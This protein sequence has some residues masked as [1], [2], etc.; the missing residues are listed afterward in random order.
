MSESKTV[1]PRGKINFIFLGILFVAV[2]IYGYYNLT[3][4]DTTLFLPL[5]VEIDPETNEKIT[6]GLTIYELAI[7]GAH[8]VATTIA[9]I[10]AKQFWHTGQKIL[11][12][13]YLALSIGMLGNLLGWVG[14]FYFALFDPNVDNNPY[15]YWNDIAFMVWHAGALVHLRLTTHRFQP[16]LNPKQLFVLFVIPVSIA[17]IYVVNY[18][19]EAFLIGDNGEFTFNPNGISVDFDEAA[20]YTDCLQ[21]CYVTSISFVFLNPLMFSYALVGLSVFRKGILGP[22]WILL[23]LGIGLTLFADI[24][25]YYSE[26]FADFAQHDWYTAFYFAS[27]LIMAY[28]LYKHRDL[29]N[30]VSS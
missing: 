14:W 30:Y 17:G 19:G 20:E 27:P 26:V 3:D 6:K 7:L 10:V 5:S 8:V 22:S 16:K 9:F 29:K 2:I 28:A 15:P 24:P 25:Y 23:I 11:Q 18:S 4:V 12:N 1:S 21:L 13:A